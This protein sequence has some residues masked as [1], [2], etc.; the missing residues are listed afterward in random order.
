MSA[1]R[2]N[3]A[4]VLLFLTLGADTHVLF[5]SKFG[6]SVALLEFTERNLMS[7]RGANVRRAD[8]NRC[9]ADTTRKARIHSS[10]TVVGPIAG[11]A[12]GPESSNHPGTATWRDGERD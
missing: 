11:L 12:N 2:V 10:A 8:S 5:L 3:L 4:Q 9:R 1:P 6:L 7:W